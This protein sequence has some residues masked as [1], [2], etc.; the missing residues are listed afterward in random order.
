MKYLAF[1]CASENI[2]VCVYN[3]AKH[4]FVTKLNSSGTENLMGAID[5]CL[6]SANMQV[7]DIDC[8]G[9]GIGPG[10]WTGAR[11]GVVTALGIVSGLKKQIKVIS[12]NSFD[13]VSYNEIDRDLPVLAKAYANFV[14]LKKDEVFQCVD[15]DKVLNLDCICA[16]NLTSKTKVVE[17][18]IDVVVDRKIKNGE[19]LGIEELEPLYLRLSQ[20]EIQLKNKGGKS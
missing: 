8:I 1:D 6:K 11:V 17:P 7:S 12:F 20:A 2:Y 16:H 3:D 15:I 19:F 13:M 10:S 5:E 4:F 9:V 14:Y 18:K